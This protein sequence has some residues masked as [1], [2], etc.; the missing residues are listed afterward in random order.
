M[1]FYDDACGKY[2]LKTAQTPIK[3]E[4]PSANMSIWVCIGGVASLWKASEPYREA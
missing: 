3:F 1:G 4:E 2:L